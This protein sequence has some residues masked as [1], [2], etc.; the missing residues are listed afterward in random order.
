[1]PPRQ[2]PLSTPVYIVKADRMASAEFEGTEMSMEANGSYP[3][4]AHGDGGPVRNLNTVIV[5]RKT[6]VI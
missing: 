4:M 3:V 1:L 6:T 2:Q 5:R